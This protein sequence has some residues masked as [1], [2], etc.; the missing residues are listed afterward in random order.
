MIDHRLR[1]A[2]LPIIIAF[3]AA[4]TCAVPASARIGWQPAGVAPGLQTPIVFVDALKQSTPWLSASPLA[5]DGDGQITALALGQTA[6]RLVYAA[7]QLRPVGDYTLLYDG[8][9]SFGF[10]GA[11][12]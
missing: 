3:S 4:L 8:A 10:D 6:S 11:T 1:V 5:E 2:V 9:G 12:I 7:G